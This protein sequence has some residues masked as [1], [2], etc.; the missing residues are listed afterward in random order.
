MKPIIVDIVK[1]ETFEEYKLFLD[2]ITEAEQAL[3]DFDSKVIFQDEMAI[4][5]AIKYEDLGLLLTQQY[6]ITKI[7]HDEMLPYEIEYKGKTITLDDVRPAFRFEALFMENY[8]FSFNYFRN[9]VNKYYDIEEPEKKYYLSFYLEELG[10]L[11]FYKK[12]L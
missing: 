12:E 1:S 11:N 9:L 6:F 3:K 4:R 8:Y 7:Y 10:L 2:N 5:W